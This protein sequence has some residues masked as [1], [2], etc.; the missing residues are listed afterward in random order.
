[1]APVS[2]PSS[3]HRSWVP[4]VPRFWA[5]GK[6]GTGK[7]GTGKPG[8]GKPGTN[9]TFPPYRRQ[10]QL[11]R[12]PAPEHGDHATQSL[13]PAIIHLVSTYSVRL[14]IP[15]QSCQ[16]LPL[17][18]I[19]IHVTCFCIYLFRISLSLFHAP[20]PGEISMNPHAFR[21]GLASRPIPL[22]RAKDGSPGREP[23]EGNAGRNPAPAG[24]ERNPHCPTNGA[25]RPQNRP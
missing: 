22:Q 2:P 14:S 19:S 25:K 12:D 3:S 11:R 5:P 18:S 8:T 4:P 15:P 16:P 10:R 21:P 6:P 24:G 7:P 9:G 1:M 17:V 13:T 20:E 23:G